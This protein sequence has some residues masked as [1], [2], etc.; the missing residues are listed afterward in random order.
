MATRAQK[1]NLGVFLVTTAV[2]VVVVLMIFGGLELFRQRDTYYVLFDGSVSGLEPGSPVKV[3]GVTMGSV[4]AVEVPRDRVETVIVTLD[5]EEDAPIRA[6]ASATLSYWGITGLKYVEV[7][8]GSDEAP[9]L[10]PGSRIPARRGALDELSEKAEA[11]ADKA[12][13]ALDRLLE[14]ATDAN[15]DRIE[16]SLVSLEEAMHNVRRF[17]EELVQA[18]DDVKGLAADARQS[19]RRAS[20]RFERAAGNVEGASESAARAARKA[21]ELMT[22]LRQA[23]DRNERQLRT[24]L[25][26]LRVATQTFKELARTLRSRPSLLFFS[27]PP[28][29]RRIP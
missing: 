24:V 5:V 29:E 23:V 19:V 12:S 17:S 1:A 7:D 14:L 9:P 25:S 6:D 20:A 4:A 16:R 8:P 10:P 15:L 22:D 27:R 3:N 26:N 28:P 21:D 13:R 11:L 2:L 18:G